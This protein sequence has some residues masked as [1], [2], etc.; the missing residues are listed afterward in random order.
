MRLIIVLGVLFVLASCSDSDMEENNVL[1]VYPDKNNLFVDMTV[2]GIDDLEQCRLKAKE[3]IEAMG[4]ENADYECGIKCV[5]IPDP[6]D[7]L[8]DSFICEETKR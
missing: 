5:K 7:G 6:G 4:Y 2:E 3:Y 8:G 1:S